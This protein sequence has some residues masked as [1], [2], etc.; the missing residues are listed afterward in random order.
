[1]NFI[2]RIQ[3]LYQDPQYRREQAFLGGGVAFG[4]I[5]TGGSLG[6]ALL[7]V[8]LTMAGATLLKSK[9]DEILERKKKRDLESR[10]ETKNGLYEIVEKFSRATNVDEIREASK[11]AATHVSS[12][13]IKPTDIALLHQAARVTTH[14]EVMVIRDKWEA[15]TDKVNDTKR[16]LYELQETF[17]NH[18]K[19]LK[20]YAEPPKKEDLWQNVAKSLQSVYEQMAE[21]PLRNRL[22]LVKDATV[23]MNNY[24]TYLLHNPPAQG[25]LKN[26]RQ[27]RLDALLIDDNTLPTSR[28]DANRIGYLLEE[29]IAA[30]S[31]VPE[32]TMELWQKGVYSG[33][34]PTV[35]YVGHASKEEVKRR[36]YGFMKQE[37]LNLK[38]LQQLHPTEQGKAIVQSEEARIE[39][40]KSE[41]TLKSP[42]AER[43]PHYQTIFENDD[44]AFK[45][46]IQ[47]AAEVNTVHSCLLATNTLSSHLSSYI[48][49]REEYEVD[50]NED[51][52]YNPANLTGPLLEMTQRLE[53]LTG[54]T[55]HT[56]MLKAYCEEV[57]KT[58]APQLRQENTKTLSSSE[59][60]M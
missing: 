44:D 21:K 27:L 54:Q 59:L 11:Y 12:I 24:Q 13:K 45:R 14:A 17:K 22:Q 53:A 6:T 5:M 35:S 16:E 3:K 10:M 2:D 60:S 39:K 56:S 38:V 51:P 41:V 32:L 57:Q 8:G 31:I 43:V 30:S 26:I 33:I 52:K 58:Y 20:L 50:P 1:M 42:T 47:E 9:W 15:G 7:G 55:H 40:F 34:S 29:G 28:F 49:I 19:G 4:T 18:I 46:F 37:L 23:A 36:D 48:R 25:D